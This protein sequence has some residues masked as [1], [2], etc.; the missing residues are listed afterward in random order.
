MRRA[1]LFTLCTAFA[2]AAVAEVCSSSSYAIQKK[3][4]SGGG[5]ATSTA[6]ATNAFSSFSQPQ[7]GIVQSA[8]GGTARLGFLSGG[9]AP[10]APPGG[11][12][13]SRG[14]GRV[15]LDW[16]DNTEL[17][18]AGY[19]VYCSETQGG[20]YAQVNA[21]PVASSSYTDS[22]LANGTTYHYVVTAL[23]DAFR[24]STYSN[25]A[26]AKPLG[27]GVLGG[28]GCGGPGACVALL[29][30]TGLGLRRRG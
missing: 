22:G 23:D 29:L 14:D 16:A 5:G 27:A 19:N 6:G 26:L 24:E 11:L 4:L 1:A 20:P 7:T 28:G 8:A 10:P 3:V 17:N 30:L 18:L 25:E 13:A 21:A 2:G 15:S 9:G 12:T